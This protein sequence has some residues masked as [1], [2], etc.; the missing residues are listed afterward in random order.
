MN[1]G[2]EKEDIDVGEREGVRWG[3]VA[4]VAESEAETEAEGEGWGEVAEVE[5]SDAE[6]KRW[7]EVA[8]SEAE[9]ERLGELAAG[10]RGSFLRWK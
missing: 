8:E 2:F 9:G 4:E 3:E 10:E 6:E 5:E 7:G 1:L